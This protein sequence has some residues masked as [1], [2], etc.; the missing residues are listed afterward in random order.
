MD[1][2]KVIELWYKAFHADIASDDFNLY[3]YGERMYE[4]E[5][6]AVIEHKQTKTK[7]RIIVEQM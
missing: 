3:G 4:D 6:Y 2:Y 1:T 7:F 5:A